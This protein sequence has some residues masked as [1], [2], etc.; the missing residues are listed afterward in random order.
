MQQSAVTDWVCSNLPPTSQKSWTSRSISLSLILKAKS[1]QV[2]FA[3][4]F[5]CNFYQ[6][7]YLK[8]QPYLPINQKLFLLKKQFS[9]KISS[10]ELFLL[11]IRPN[12]SLH[13]I[14]MFY[15]IFQKCFSIQKAF[16]QVDHS[17][18]Q[19]FFKSNFH[20][21]FKHANVYSSHFTSF[22]LLKTTKNISNIIQLNNF[23]SPST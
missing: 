13:L 4:I 10:R 14:W 18:T 20:L 9:V 17:L 19:A 8:I 3:C 6:C 16:V 1:V 7:F 11:S 15:F 12:Q 21:G 5:K 22:V 23:L 2:T